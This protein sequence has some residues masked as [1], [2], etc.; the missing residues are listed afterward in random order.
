MQVLVSYMLVG[1][2]RQIS[3]YGLLSAALRHERSVSGFR[4]QEFEGQ[5][6]QVC[7]LILFFLG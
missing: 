3:D 6:L 4:A 1:I 7:L 5:S 2:R